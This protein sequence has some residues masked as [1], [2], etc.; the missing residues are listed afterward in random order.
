VTPKESLAI[1]HDHE[2]MSFESS[3]GSGDT[4]GRQESLQSTPFGDTLPFKKENILRIGFQ[5]FGGFP[6]KR[7]KLKEDL[8][9]Q[10][11]KKWDFDVF[12]V[13]ETNVDWRLF[14]EEDKLPLRTRDWWDNQHVCW[15]FNSTSA[16]FEPRQYGGTAVFST[17]QAAHR[18]IEKGFD[19]SHLGRRAWTRYKGRGAH[20]LRIISAYRLTLLPVPNQ[21]LPNTMPISFPKLQIAA[22]VKHLWRT[23][24]RLY[25]TLLRRGTKL[26]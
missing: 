3:L 7:S 16:P 8:M 24:S 20:T 17:N 23:Y 22:L 11:L 21:S 9:R 5:N 6:V 1:V 4:E 12:G 18:V 25:K 13:T 14:R 2:E 26:F 15:A 19:P 10:G